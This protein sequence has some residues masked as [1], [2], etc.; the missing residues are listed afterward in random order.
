MLIDKKI[1]DVFNFITSKDIRWHDFHEVGFEQDY[2]DYYYAED[3]LYLIRDR[4]TGQIY[5][6]EARSPIMAFKSLED[7]H[8]QIAEGGGFDNE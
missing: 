4:I 5:F 3:G 1:Q 8:N 7:I 2:Y 6:V